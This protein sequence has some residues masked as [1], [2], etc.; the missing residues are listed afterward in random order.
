MSGD[1]L[2]DANAKFNIV[3]RGEILPGSDSEAVKANVAKLFKANEATLK[4]LFSGQTIVIKKSVDK[5]N[6]MKYRA[7]MKKAG[8][9]C[10]SEAC[11]VTFN[12]STA[13]N[14]QVKPEPPES[15]NQ[16]RDTA[17][18]KLS[19][20]Y[21]SPSMAKTND[22]SGWTIA[23]VGS[24]IGEP[25][26]TPQIE[27]PETIDMSLAD[28]GVNIIENPPKPAAQNPVDVSHIGLASVGSILHDS[29]LDGL[30]HIEV[31]ELPDISAIGI[32][33]VG[34]DILDIK[35]E[36]PELVVDISHIKLCSD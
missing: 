33:A 18:E 8:A 26:P 5:P 15:S 35:S 17:H 23:P 27:I 7:L 34:A 28:A 9:L 12:D 10:Y 29:D 25:F 31:I 21:S 30:T 4:R 3:F 11:E 16:A 24:C 6:A 2:S 13:S 36:T 22:Q 32:A 1:K 14:Q 20:T 19:N